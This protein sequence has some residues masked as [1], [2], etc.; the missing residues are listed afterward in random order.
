ML[1]KRVAVRHSCEIIADMTLGLAC[2]LDF[3][4]KSWRENFWIIKISFKETKE[5]L[6]RITKYVICE[7]RL[8][9]WTCV[10]VGHHKNIGEVIEENQRQGWR[11]HTYQAQGSPTIVNHYLL[12]ERETKE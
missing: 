12:F 9:K 6:V 11:L 10:Q 8:K 7:N 4:M 1:Q 3:T 5:K 2:F